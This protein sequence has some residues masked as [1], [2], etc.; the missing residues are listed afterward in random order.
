MNTQLKDKQANVGIEGLF[1]KTPDGEIRLNGATPE[2][3]IPAICAILRQLPKP[4]RK[5]VIQ[6]VSLVVNLE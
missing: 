1:E 6:A 2:S 4:E 3:V 5:K